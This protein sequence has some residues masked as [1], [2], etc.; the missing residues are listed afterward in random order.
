MRMVDKFRAGRVLVA[1]DAA[2]VHSATGGQ[3]SSLIDP[4]NKAD[5]IIIYRD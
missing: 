4:T 3:V 1:G 2:H 5:S